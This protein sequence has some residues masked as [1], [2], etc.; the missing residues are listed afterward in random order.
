M[1]ENRFKIIQ[2]YKGFEISLTYSRVSWAYYSITKN[3]KPI[4]ILAFYSAKGCKNIID[5]HLQ[6]K[7]NE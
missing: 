5:T 7:N 2:I 4:S 3:K 1:P 6:N